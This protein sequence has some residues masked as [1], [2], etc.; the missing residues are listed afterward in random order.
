MLRLLYI[1][2]SVPTKIMEIKNEM[3]HQFVGKCWPAAITA[4]MLT[5]ARI[6]ISLILIPM[7][8]DLQAWRLPAIF[9]F[10]IG[11]LTDMLDG[12]VARYFKTADLKGGAI[13]PIADKLFLFPFFIYYAFTA[14]YYCSSVVILLI[15]SEI[16]LG[17]IAVFSVLWKIS[18]P[19]NSF[20]KWKLGFGSTSI[21]VLLI[22]ANTA[23]ASVLFFITFALSIGSIYG[24]LL[25]FRKTA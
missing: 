19:S 1:S 7:I 22:F 3:L 20:G 24:H 2:L 17:A 13:D 8:F 12:P 4:N 9:L 21:L 25:P 6:A 16:I 5:Y 23:T 18:T 14:P 10:S 15:C 11:L